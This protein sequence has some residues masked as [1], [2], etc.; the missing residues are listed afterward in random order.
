MPSE[1]PAGIID[2]MKP[3]R[4]VLLLLLA[5]PCVAEEPPRPVAKVVRVVDGDTIVV[6][7]DGQKVTVRLWRATSAA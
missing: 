2:C 1:H 4:F 5:A 7:L 3:T 6:L